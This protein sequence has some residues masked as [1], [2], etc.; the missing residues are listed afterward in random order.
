M[1]YH[2]VL[3]NITNTPFKGNLS[4]VRYE[5]KERFNQCFNGFNGEMKKTHEVVEEGISEE[6]AIQLT[7]QQTTITN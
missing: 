6:R 2:V 4:W 3:R 1:C 7:Q 5:S